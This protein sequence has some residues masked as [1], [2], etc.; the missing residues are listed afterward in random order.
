MNFYIFY[1]III[2]R[3]PLTNRYVDSGTLT[4]YKMM[5]TAIDHGRISDVEYLIKNGNYTLSMMDEYL[6]ESITEYKNCNIFK[7]LL[8]LLKVKE[9]DMEYYIEQMMRCNRLDMFKHVFKESCI[10]K[11]I[12]KSITLDCLSIFT[13]LLEFVTLK[14]KKEIYLNKYL[15]KAIQDNSIDLFMKL[16]TLSEKKLNIM[17]DIYLR[18]ACKYHVYSKIINYLIQNG[19]NELFYI[20]H[21]EKSKNIP[22]NFLQYIS[23]FYNKNAIIIQRGCHN[24]LY[25]PKC[26][27]N[28]IG[29]VPRLDMRRLGIYP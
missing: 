17:K 24:W 7:S 13:Y 25:K 23:H 20:R 5:E 29:I 8:P 21:L 1:K 6:R 28:T 14:D 12:E 2:M 4:Y 26:N 16:L 3:N 15:S 18:Y 10:D 19:A 11:Y 9:R 22:K 27:D